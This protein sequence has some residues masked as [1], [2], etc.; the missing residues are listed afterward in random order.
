MMAVMDWSCDSPP[1]AWMWIP[2]CHEGMEAWLRYLHTSY[3]L[4][5]AHK[6]HSSLEGSYVD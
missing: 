4:I 6:G 1:E 5:N 3:R 2:G